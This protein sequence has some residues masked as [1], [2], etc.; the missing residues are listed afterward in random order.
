MKNKLKKLDFKQKKYI[1]PLVALPFVLLIGS[2]LMGFFEEED[3]VK[4]EEQKE[5]ATSLGNVSDSILTKNEAYDQ[6]FKRV[7]DDRSMIDGLTKEQDSLLSYTDNLDEKQ[8]RFIDSLNYVR[9]LNERNS[10][11]DNDFSRR[12]Y[13]SDKDFKRQDKSMENHEK[14]QD[15]EDYKR[16]MEMIRMLNGETQKSANQ[17]NTLPQKEEKY[18]NEEEETDPLKL[19]REQMFLM[20][21]IEKARNPELKAQKEAEERL[22]ANK[23]KMRAFLNSTLKVSKSGTSRQF[24]HI[25]KEK[26]DD[27]IKAV[28]DENVKGYLGSR[29]RIR[30]LEDV[31]VGKYKIDKGT[32]LY[33]QISGFSLQRVNLNIVSILHKGEILPVNL[34]IYDVDGMKGLYV[35]AS[36]FREMTRELGSNAVQGTNLERG[37]EDFFTS[38]ASKIFQSTSQTIANLVR[39]NK[40]KLKYNSYLLLINEKDLKDYEK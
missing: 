38:F 7:E 32:I 37:S 2:Q 30:L 16:S 25:G 34:S 24:N 27:F 22:L 1:L 19:M 13:Y 31:Y 36:A 10:E 29:I 6:L 39:K 26:N 40:A 23:A 35:P 20:D 8:K 15:D 18:E 11:R 12:E 3:E 17:P 28:I 5:L 14:K 9:K 21:S 4:I 33:G